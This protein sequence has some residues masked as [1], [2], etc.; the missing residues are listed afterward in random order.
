MAWQQKIEKRKARCNELKGELNANMDD[1]PLTTQ[2]DKAAYNQQL[3]AYMI[4]F[5]NFRATM[6]IQ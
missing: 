6:Y 5:P 3:T 1:A 4:I 2:V